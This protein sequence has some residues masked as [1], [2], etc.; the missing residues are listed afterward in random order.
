MNLT[1]TNPKLSLPFFLDIVDMN[2]KYGWSK[3][4][5]YHI[6]QW[7]SRVSD[8]K[9]FPHHL[10]VMENYRYD[11]TDALVQVDLYVLIM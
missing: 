10:L 3:H 4:T 1:H 9:I 7:T 5:Q 8:L 11:I 2:I 6:K